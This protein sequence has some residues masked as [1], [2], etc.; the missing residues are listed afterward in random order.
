MSDSLWK[1]SI[2]KFVLNE[3]NEAMK[4]LEEITSRMKRDKT[5]PDLLRDVGTYLTST[6][7]ST[8]VRACIDWCVGKKCCCG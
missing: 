7:V 5:F 4:G 3:K 8:R 6:D 2:D 1:S